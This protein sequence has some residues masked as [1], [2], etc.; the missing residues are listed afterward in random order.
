MCAQE[1]LH[2]TVSGFCHWAITVKEEVNHWPRTP[3]MKSGRKTDDRIKGYLSVCCPGTSV[4][5]LS[6]RRFSL[7]L[8]CFPWDN[9]CDE[10]MIW[11]YS[12]S[13]QAICHANAWTSRDRLFQLYVMILFIC[14]QKC[15]N[16]NL[17]SL[18]YQMDLDLRI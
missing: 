17:S 8:I 16:C 4:K 9:E 2:W 13:K 15:T 11:V 7:L 6:F 5:Q 10:K 18:A 1:K 14:E 3:L 12:Y